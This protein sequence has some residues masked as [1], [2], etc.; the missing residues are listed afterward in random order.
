MIMSVYRYFGAQWGADSS[1]DIIEKTAKAT[2]VSSKTVRRVIQQASE[3]GPNP[4][5]SPVYKK[6]T[7][8]VRDKLDD[9][10][11]E[12]IRREILAFYE[13]GEVPTLRELLKK[14]KE[15]PVSYTGGETTLRTIVREIGFKYSKVG[16]GRAIIME[17][18][19]IVVK[20]NKYLR[21]KDKNRN[22]SPSKRRPEVYLDET[23]VNQNECVAKCWTTGGTV[24][25]KIKTGKGGR[26]IILHAGGKNG[27]IPEGLLMF[28]SA[29][30]NKSDYHD[31][32]DHER[33][34]KWFTE[35]LLPNIEKNS[36]II[37]DNASYHSKKRNK[38]PTSKNRKDEIIAW[39]TSN[40]IMFDKTLTKVELLDITKQYNDKEI[41]II[42]E[43]AR[44]HGHEILRLP[45]YHCQLN[46]IELIW[47]QI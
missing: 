40:K 27:F 19:D 8:P 12:C 46:P 42:D 15:E 36:L 2:N 21:L 32:M 20:R 16:S 26:F 6:R 31:A 37:M 29:N 30:G 14:V 45:P 39:L 38:M 23:W 44:A 43:I 17:K 33:F 9:F 7:Q 3:S 11:K 35:Q 34:L 10:D 5:T 18:G 28:K 47:A 22:S 4:F 1:T 25:P 24:G 41:Y 13:R